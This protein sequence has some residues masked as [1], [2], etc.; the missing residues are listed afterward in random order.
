LNQANKTEAAADEEKTDKQG[1][2][3]VEKNKT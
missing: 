3:L 2:D 1:E